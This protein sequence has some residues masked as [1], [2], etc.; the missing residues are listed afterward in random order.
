MV[1][2]LGHRLGQLRGPVDRVVVRRGS[3]R[4]PRQ[5]GGTKTADQGDAGAAPGQASYQEGQGAGAGWVIASV[6]AYGRRILDDSF[7]LIFHSDHEP[8]AF[9]L[10]K[11][12]GKAPWKQCLDTAQGGFVDDDRAYAAGEALDVAARSVRVL[13]RP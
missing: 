3:D 7:Y 12:L 5:R 1:P 13:C 4:E 10:P 6:D 8:L 2:A 9:T 11:A